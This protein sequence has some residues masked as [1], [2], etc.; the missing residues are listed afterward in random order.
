MS[1]ESN[2][3]QP[4]PFNHLKMGYVVAKVYNLLVGLILAEST[5][6]PVN[7]E[8]QSKKAVNT[9]SFDGF[10]AGFEKDLT[11]P[12]L[13]CEADALTIVG[14]PIVETATL[15]DS[16]TYARLHM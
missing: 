11:D 3:P 5:L 13:S 15:S 9:N 16:I 1:F 4:P 7:A 12:R 2:C 10:Q 6:V 14:S 8:R